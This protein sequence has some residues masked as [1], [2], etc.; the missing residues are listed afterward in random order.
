ML[1]TEASLSAPE[2]LAL[3]NSGSLFVAE[4]NGQRIRKIVL[5][6]DTITT[7]AGTGDYGFSGDGGPATAA[8]LDNP[9]Y[10]AVDGSGHL[11]IADTQNGRI[12]EVDP[13]TGIITEFAGGGTSGLGDNGPAT[14][15][16]LS[17]PSGIAVD[18][19]GNVYIADSWNNRIRKVDH[20]THFITTVAGSGSAGFSGDGDPA[21]TASLNGPWGI[22]LDSNGHLF[23]ADCYNHRIREVDLSTKIITT[24]AG[25]GNSLGDN[26]PVVSAGVAPYQIATDAGGNLFIADCGYNR[27]REIAAG[28]TC[29]NTTPAT[30][31]VTPNAASR[32]YGGA[33]PTF[34]ATI[35]GF[36]N[37]E[38]LATS[39]V[40]GSPV[41]TPNNA[42]TSPVGAYSITASL[43]TLA[44]QNYNFTFASGALDITP[45]PLMASVTIGDKVYDCTTTATITGRSLSGV[46]GSDDVSLTGGTGAFADKKRRHAQRG[47]GDWPE[48]DRCRRRQLYG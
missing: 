1:A 11:L 44:A 24:F 45:A 8:R 19:S 6:T 14:S 5:S 17:G 13:L 37:G 47:D 30:L 4:Q 18:A 26:G 28:N 34:T 36:Q 43:G 41:L 29:V 39:G 7:V 9:Q 48:P 12:R 42:S 40:S 23:I 38:T 46:I 32:F 16:S 25:G 21:T 22:A 3:D 2:G 15:A 31:T 27:I 33:E 35:N 10:V 20:T